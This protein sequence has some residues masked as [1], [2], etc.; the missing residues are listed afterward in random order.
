MNSKETMITI[1]IPVYNAGKTI[2]TCLESLVN[3]KTSRK[4]EIIF[5]DDGSEDNSLNIMNSMKN[6][7][8][9]SVI[10]QSNS[11]PAKARNVGAKLAKGDILVFTDSDC[12]LDVY[13][14]EEMT[15]PFDD[16]DVIGVQ[17]SYKTKQKGIIPR[18]EQY[19][20]EN[21]Y[22][23]YNRNKYIDA[24]GTYSAAYRRMIFMKYGGFNTTYKLASGEDFDLSYKMAADGH[25]M[26]FN[27]KAICY[28][29]HPDSLLSYLKIKHK[30]GYWRVLLYGNHSDKIIS[31]SYTPNIQKYQFMLVY[32]TIIL[33]LLIIYNTAYLTIVILAF[34]VYMISCMSNMV[35]AFYVT[36]GMA[37]LVPIITYLRAIVFGV[38]MIRGTFALINK[39][40][41]IL[42]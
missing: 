9:I 36:P 1:I 17:G 2:Q 15:K 30:R 24:I 33:S 10:S 18:Y 3:Q 12:E 4:Y 39:D 21:S 14:L 26:V 6:K 20:I 5:I 31:D 35:R 40:K 13:W 32:V 29:Q 27:N 42:K 25:R 28:H 37:I 8:D 7:G 41:K 19:E 23:R 38:G 11:G 16:E 34:V 22:I